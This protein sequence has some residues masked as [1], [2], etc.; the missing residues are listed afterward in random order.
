[1][2]PTNTQSTWDSK[3]MSDQISV[4]RAGVHAEA[5]GALDALWSAWHRYLVMPVKFTN[6]FWDE[7]SQTLKV[8]TFLH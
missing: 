3:G 2:L 4:N 6:L 1:M 8:S 7:M 5:K